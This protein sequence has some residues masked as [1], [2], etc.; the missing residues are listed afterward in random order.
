M[1]LSD[2]SIGYLS[3]IGI[4]LILGGLIFGMWQAHRE[5]SHTAIVDFPEL[6]SLQPEDAVTDR[7]YQ[8]GRVGSV[9]WLGHKARIV[10]LFDEPIVLREGTVFRNI[11]YALMGQ[12]RVDVIRSKTGHK[13]SEDHIYQGEFVPGV[14]ETLRLMES[15]VAQI[16]GIQE[17]VMLIALGN[18]TVPSVP[19]LFNSALKSADSIVNELENM[20]AEVQPKI[21]SLLNQTE[22]ASQTVIA[23]SG[24]ADSTIRAIESQA[25]DKIQDANQAIHELSEGIAKID[26]ITQAIET[27]PTAQNLLNSR[28]KI[29]KVDSLITT[30]N[31]LIKA[32]NTKGFALYDEN[33]KKISLI[34]WENLNLIG[35]TAREKAKQR[36]EQAK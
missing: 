32:I 18:D 27:N 6:G 24:T 1:K 23:V 7:G 9:T 17:L 20:T 11:N 19:T 21:N 14:A 34:T 33:G 3:F 4:F 10:I 5:T 15:I 12:R 26:T 8:V 29:D 36:Q 22:A 30:V 13:L 35:A 2:K 31:G 28:E 16:K 25:T